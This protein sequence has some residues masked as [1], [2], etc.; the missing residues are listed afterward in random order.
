[1]QR[2]IEKLYNPLFLY[3]KKRVNS[4]EDAEDLTQEVFYKLSKSQSDTVDNVKSWVYTIAKNTITDYYRKK[5]VY[6]EGINEISFTY[7]EEEEDA[8]KE[9]SKCVNSFID[10]LPEEYRSIMTLSELENVSQKEIAD[11]LDM[12][13]VTVRSKIQ[14]GRKKLKELFSECCIIIQGGKGS[15]LSYHQKEDCDENNSCSD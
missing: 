9:L 3:V 10:E 5:K 8:S 6:F 7:E 12:N 15:I 1:M 2:Q 4:R 14:R 13:Y 11:R